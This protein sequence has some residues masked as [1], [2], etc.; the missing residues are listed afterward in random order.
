MARRTSSRSKPPESGWLAKLWASLKSQ[1]L[2]SVLFFPLAFFVANAYLSDRSTRDG[3]VQAIN[4]DRLTKFQESGKALDLKVAEYFDAVAAQ[5]DTGKPKEV[6]RA[7]LRQHGADV[8]ALRGVLEPDASRHYLSA[9]ANL[10]AAIEADSDISKTPS[11]ITALGT[12]VVE[13]NRLVDKAMQK[14][15]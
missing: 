14:V 5:G 3:R 15:G 2:A 4:V 6:A 13:R 7:A 8:Q 1:W 11:N 10:S 9:L 12:L